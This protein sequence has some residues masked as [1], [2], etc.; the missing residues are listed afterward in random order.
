MNGRKRSAIGHRLIDF[1]LWIVCITN[2]KIEHKS[3]K[4]NKNKLNR[5][6]SLKKMAKK[7]RK[8]IRFWFHFEREN[9]RMRTATFLQANFPN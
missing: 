8:T 1:H 9:A 3:C 7:N 5:A 2:A 6:N 4:E